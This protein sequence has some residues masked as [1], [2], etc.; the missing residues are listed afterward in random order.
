MTQPECRCRVQSERTHTHTHTH[1]HSTRS[2]SDLLKFRFLAMDCVS[3]CASVKQV[4]IEIFRSHNIDR[5]M[6]SLTN[7]RI[8]LLYHKHTKCV[9]ARQ[10][11]FQLFYLQQ[12]RKKNYKS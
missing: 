9:Y 2:N 12:K 8:Q 3:V 1:M 5:I 6:K 11:F 7:N 10:P 4:Q